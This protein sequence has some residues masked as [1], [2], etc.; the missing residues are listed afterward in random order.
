[1]RPFRLFALCLLLS[2][3]ATAQREVVPGPDAGTRRFGTSILALP[4]GNYLVTDPEWSAGAGAD[5]AGAV[6]LYAA[7]GS[8]LSRLNG[9]SANDAIGSGGIVLLASGD[10]VVQSPRWDAPGGV[11]DAGAVTWGHRDTG[12]GGN[13]IVGADNSLVGSSSGDVVGEQPVVA[14]V[15]GSYVVPSGNWDRAGV[16]VNAGAAT[17][18]AADGSTTGAISAAN[19]LVGSQ[20]DDRVAAVTVAGTAGVVALANGH[21]VVASSSWDHGALEDAG[22]ATWG[23]DDGSV[24]GEVSAAN[25]LVGARAAD[26]VGTQVQALSQGHYIVQSWLWDD[27]VSTNVGAVTW[28][29]GSGPRSDTVTALNSLVGSQPGDRVGYLAA[30]LNN[31]NYVVASPFWSNGPVQYAGAATWRD[32]TGP[33]PGVV[34]AG[35]SLVGTRYGDSIGYLSVIGLPAL[36]VVP[37]ANGNYVVASPEWNRSDSV[38]RAGAATWGDGANGTSGPVDIDNSFVGA[39]TND[40]IAQYA[41]ALGNGDYVVA[42]PYWS[43]RRGAATFGSGSAASSGEVGAANSLVGERSTDFISAS[44]V[45]DL[46]DGGYALPTPRFGRDDAPSLGAIS[47]AAPGSGIQG[48]ISAGNSFTGTLAGDRAGAGGLIALANGDLLVRSAL[49]SG[50]GA[51]T[52]IPAGAMPAT[53]PIGAANSLVGRE[54]DRI[55][56]PGPVL[57]PDG[58]I[59]A[60][61]AGGAQGAGAI[62]LFAPHDPFRGALPEIDTV[63]SAVA[64]GGS[65]L[66]HAYL[67][68]NATLLVGDPAGNRLIRLSRSRIFHHGFD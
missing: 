56:G 49:A 3:P 43:G 47:R 4:N 29:D 40:A 31:G 7:D 45:L 26:H 48:T 57:L 2:P 35:N 25:S 1:M 16:A 66:S 62:T 5:R 38:T 27:G 33:H 8:S 30:I 42:S 55:G 21:Y 12:F 39:V 18:G 36:G 64:D 10:F 15:N 34:G 37:L 46:P 14:L 6:Y 60:F 59:V 13:A 32:G 61:S 22:A 51:L 41:V 68:P 24:V 44:G 53:V 28:V 58:A 52:R 67:V 65:A 23:R 63:R 17:W 54:D 20:P 11:S 19:S 50:F 9:S